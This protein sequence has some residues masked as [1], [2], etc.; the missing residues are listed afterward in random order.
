[1]IEHLTKVSTVSPCAMGQGCAAL[2][3]SWVSAGCQLGVTRSSF[4]A[5]K[6]KAGRPRRQQDRVLTASLEGAFEQ[7]GHTYGSPRLVRALRAQGIATSK[8]RP[9]GT[10]CGV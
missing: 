9:G 2:G 8:I 3:V 6:H 7:S 10:R 5:H 4:Y 1:V